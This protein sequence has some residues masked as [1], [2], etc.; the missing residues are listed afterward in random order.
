MDKIFH[1]FIFS[2]LVSVTTYAGM[3]Q[4]YIIL[5]AEENPKTIVVETHKYKEIL[6][7]NETL[8]SIVKKHKIELE[9]S[10]V[11]DTN[12]FKVG[13]FSDVNILTLSYLELRQSFPQAFIS[14]DL[15]PSIEQ[16]GEVRYRKKED[17]SLWLAL[18]SLA[19]IGIFG[20]FLS[21]REVK[22]LKKQHNKLENKQK[23]IEKKQSLLLEKMGEKIQD[24][25]LK[26]VAKETK[27]LAAPLEIFDKK[28]IKTHIA[29]LKRNDEDLLRTT[30]EMI[31]FLKIKSGN[32]VVK[33]EAFQLS[34]MLHKLTNAIAP[35]LREKEYTLYYDIESNVTRYLIGDTNRTFQ[36]L[37]NLF[38][39]MLERKDYGEVVIRIEIR[40]DDIL[41]FS[42]KNEALF[43]NADEVETLFVPQ[44]W[45]D[46]HYKHKEFG[47]YVLNELVENMGGKLSIESFEGKGITYELLLP[48]IRDLDNKSRKKDLVKVLSSKKALIIDKNL[49]SAKSLTEMLKTFEIDVLFKSSEN[50]ETHRPDFDGV[51]FV[52]LKSDD[53]SKKVFEFFKSLDE[54]ERPDII[55]VHNIF[56]DHHNFEEASYIADA[57]LYSPLI[58]GDVEESLKQLYIRKTRRKKDIRQESL[59]DFR[60]LNALKVEIGDFSKFKDKTILI[61]EDNFVSQQ[62]MSTIL[63]ASQLTIIN[64]E[65]GQEALDILE[66]YVTI[67]LIFMD[68]DMPIIDGFDV[69]RII[70]KNNKY[71]NIPIVAV[72]GLGFYNEIED[73]I[74]SGIDA[75][76]IKPYRFGQLYAALERFLD[77]IS[78]NNSFV[79]KHIEIE[80]Q[81]KMVLDIT[82]GLS[83][84]RSEIFYN[85]IAA[86]ILLA[87]RNSDNLVK[88]MIVKD[89]IEELRAFCVDA[90]GLSA[91]IGA[92][93]YVVLLKE[94]LMEMKKEEVYLSQYIPK[95]KE[96]WLELELEMKRFLKR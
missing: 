79:E 66:E 64:A 69:T 61:V 3:E 35:S 38:L 25:A 23:E 78:F 84:V 58:V 65:N 9:I 14:Q 55:I 53:V 18:F 86:Q 80:N 34:S 96:K 71:K 13:P 56:D 62:V 45:E 47:F 1:S 10:K 95:Y 70:K 68:L 30:Y 57:V 74:L 67:D 75:C 22:K 28:E 63:S 19:T 36:V 91:T 42:I 15:K 8:N 7:N 85:E 77:P 24:A 59:K 88:E 29:S 44:S 4:S 32:I 72:T 60:I 2:S 40:D 73:M 76:I 83:Y 37:H 89:N 81:N 20:L 90:L 52:I 87:L 6:T 92:T 46:V 16:V 21:S 17:R 33:Q 82:K 26:N 49:Y 5:K 11:D 94:M 31:D 54:K 93:G 51:D 43:L 12:I 48:Y 41:V 50:L 27:L 39:D